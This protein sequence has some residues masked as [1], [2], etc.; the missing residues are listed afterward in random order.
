MRELSDVTRNKNDVLW[1]SSTL[2]LFL[3]EGTPIFII[4]PS[5]YSLQMFF[6]FGRVF[7]LYPFGFPSP[8]TPPRF[9]DSPPRNSC[10]YLCVRVYALVFSSPLR[11]SFC[12]TSSAVVW[13]S[14]SMFDSHSL[15]LL[16]IRNEFESHFE[17]K[18]KILALYLA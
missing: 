18:P 5:E 8:P 10:V 6:L 7:R 17:S 4:I 15:A 9:P 12:E 13:Y 11:R 2:D 3:E 14:V 1:M 16:L